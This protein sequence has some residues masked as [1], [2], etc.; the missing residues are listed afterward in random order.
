VK[1][2]FVIVSEVDVV[3]LCLVEGDLCVIGWI[4]MLELVVVGGELV[5]SDV[6]L[7]E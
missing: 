6:E 5:V 7:V 4:D 1:C 2:V 3:W